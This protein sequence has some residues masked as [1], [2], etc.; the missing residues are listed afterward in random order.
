[1]DDYYAQHVATLEVAFVSRILFPSHAV[2]GIAIEVPHQLRMSHDD[3]VK[4]PWVWSIS[5]SLLL[6]SVGIQRA[7]FIRPKE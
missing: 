7:V 2:I 4:G 5:I 6:F 1:M 3:S